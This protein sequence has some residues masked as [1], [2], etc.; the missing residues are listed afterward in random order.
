[1]SDQTDLQ[2]RMAEK[3]LTR[4]SERNGGGDETL[5]ARFAEARHVAGGS[6]GSTAKD[7]S[8]NWAGGNHV[9]SVGRSDQPLSADLANVS[10]VGSSSLIPS[11]NAPEPASNVRATPRSDQ[12][13]RSGVNAIVRGS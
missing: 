2:V 3:A 8:L 13:Q 6:L 11:V 1:M 7:A 12:G 5:A 10:G 9:A 4:A